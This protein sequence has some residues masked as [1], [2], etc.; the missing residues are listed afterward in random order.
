MEHYRQLMKL[1]NEQMKG[2]GV[3]YNAKELLQN[4][5]GKAQNKFADAQNI[6]TEK[7]NIVA[8]VSNKHLTGI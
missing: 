2:R 1:V 6:A 8:K 3:L 4:V 5:T 7:Y